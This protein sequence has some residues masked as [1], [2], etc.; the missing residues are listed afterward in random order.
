M[1]TWLKKFVKKLPV[2]FTKNQKYDWQTFQII[3]KHCSINSNCIDVGCH[4]GEILDLMIKFCPDGMHSG[5]EPIPDLYNI[6]VKKYD[7]TKVR[8]YPFALSSEEGISQFN[9]VIS[10][11]AYSGLVK[12]KYD[13]PNEKDTSIEVR[14]A[15]LDDIIG[16]EKVD[17]IKIDVEGG[18]LPVLIGGKRTILKNNPLI[19]FEH[20]KGASELYGSSPKKVFDFFNELNYSIFL[21][22]SFLHGAKPLTLEKFEKEFN[23]QRNYFFIAHPE[24]PL[25]N[26]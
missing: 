13:R 10:N 12:R 14:K 8:I 22:R 11:P 7:N 15:R 6:L 5:F 16:D 18:E 4:K 23:T 3:K 20:G 25:S 9:Y 2:R 24:K 19:L 1:L 26:V 21:L 17:L